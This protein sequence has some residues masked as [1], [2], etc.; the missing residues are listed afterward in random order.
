MHSE[1]VRC[2]CWGKWVMGTQELSVL[3]LQCLVTLK[4]FQNMVLKEEINKEGKKERKGTASKYNS[5]MLTIIRRPEGT[6]PEN[7]PVCL[8]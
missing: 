7:V 1:Y 4:L 5:A 6:Q 2:Y 3:F 8:P